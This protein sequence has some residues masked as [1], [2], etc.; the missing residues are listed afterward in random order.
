[1]GHIGGER[2]ANRSYMPHVYA[3]S[4]I[5]CFFFYL[6][7]LPRVLVKGAACCRAIITSHTVGCSDVVKNGVNGLLV[8]S[9][10]ATALADAISYLLAHPEIRK[11]MGFKGREMVEI[12]FSQEKSVDETISLY[13]LISNQSS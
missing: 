1:M 7:G 4:H 10:D 6:E 8:P 9:R 5:V 13:Q 12:N 2:A 3:Q 11:R